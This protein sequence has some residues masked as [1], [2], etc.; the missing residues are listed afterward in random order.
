MKHAAVANKS[1][2]VTGCSSGIGLATAEMLRSRGWKVFPTARKVADLDM[3][4]AKGFTVLQLDLTS[5]ASIEATVDQLLFTNGGQLGAVVNN[6]GFGMPGAIEDLTRDAM[7]HQFEVN[8]F[9]LQELTNKLIPVFR[10]QGYGRIV[11]ISSVVGRISLPF[12]G[13][14]SASKFAL[15]AVSDAQRIELS[16][17]SIAVSIVEPGPIATR[18]ATNCADEGEKELDAERSLFAAAYRKYFDKRRNGGM[19]ED[20]FRLPPEAVAKKIIHA[21]ESPHPK[22]RY[23]V[24][25]PAYLGSWAARFV[26]AGLIDRTMI[27]HARKRF[28]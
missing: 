14:Y 4:E 9:G 20:R 13:I 3:L 28:G 18:F 25:I 15:E 1:V 6:A 2:L 27:R 5:S 8:L 19:A 22:I 21:L 11:N 10:K 7:R 26:P 17:D 12:M 16:P 24:T 23:C